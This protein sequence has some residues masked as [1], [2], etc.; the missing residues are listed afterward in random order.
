MANF[1]PITACN[2]NECLSTHPMYKT[3]KLVMKER[4]PELVEDDVCTLIVT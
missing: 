2:M 3:A 4:L 1:K